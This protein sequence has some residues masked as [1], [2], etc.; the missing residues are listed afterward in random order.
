MFNLK[1]ILY[2]CLRVFV[3]WECEFEGWF[4]ICIDWICF[5]VFRGRWEGIFF[6]NYLIIWS[7]KWWKSLNLSNLLWLNRGGKGWKVGRVG[8]GRREEREKRKILFD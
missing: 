4:K 6:Y 7:Y 5:F 8:R 3:M 1:F 2:V